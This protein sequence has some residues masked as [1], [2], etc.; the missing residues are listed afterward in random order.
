M[1]IN[2]TAQLESPDYRGPL[3]P[4]DV[5]QTLQSRTHPRQVSALQNAVIETLKKVFPDDGTCNYSVPTVYGWSLGEGEG[6]AGWLC[7]YHE[8]CLQEEYMSLLGV[9]IR[10]KNKK[11]LMCPVGETLQFCSFVKFSPAHSW[12][13]LANGLL[14]SPVAHGPRFLSSV[15]CED[16]IVLQTSAA[17]F[18]Y[19]FVFFF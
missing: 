5:L 18:L 13:P 19:Y 12:R 11:M 4:D 1:H 7:L 8:V 14:Q 15:E 17:T 9:K 2:A 10:K 6:G 16:K 3:L